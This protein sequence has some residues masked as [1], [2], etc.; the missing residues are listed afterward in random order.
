MITVYTGGS[1]SIP[2]LGHYNFLKQIKDLYPDSKLIVAVNTD[3]FIERYKG[4]KPEFSFDERCKFIGMVEFVD[5]V[6]PNIG[7]EDSTRTI[8]SV[9]PDVIAIGNDWLEKDYCSQ[10]GFDAK[11]LRKY[12]I[13]VSYFPYTEG[14]SVTEIK[15]RLD[16]R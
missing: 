5:K 9:M 13:T 3:E 6:I 2:H 7:N 14:I 10:M 15:R 8:L 1:F 4:R 16:V 12:H 11:W